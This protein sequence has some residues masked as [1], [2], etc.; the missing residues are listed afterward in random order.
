MV[1]LPHVNCAQQAGIPTQLLQLLPLSARH[2]L[3]ERFQVYSAQ[4][5][6]QIATLALQGNTR[7]V[8]DR[9][10]AGH[11]PWDLLL[12][13]SVRSRSRSALGVLQENSGST[14]IQTSLLVQ[15]LAD[16]DLSSRGRVPVQVP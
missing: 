11:A 12:A 8:P 3:Q 14:N 13:R 1:P 15:H 10:S 7:I 6:L 4:T 5:T 2:A 16:P 9:R